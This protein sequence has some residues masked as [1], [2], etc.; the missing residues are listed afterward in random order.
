MSKTTHHPDS[1]QCAEALKLL[2]DPTRL[3]IMQLLR[4][5]AKTVSQLLQDIQIPQNLMSHHLRVLREG[6]L[7][8]ATREGKAVR[9]ARTSTVDSTDHGGI[10]LG[11]CEVRFP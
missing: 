2:A 6:A 4:D 9:Y 3:K 11:C 7:V 5:D 10:N 1:D 8:T